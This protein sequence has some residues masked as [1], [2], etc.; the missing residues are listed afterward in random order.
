LR[1]HLHS[2]SLLPDRKSDGVSALASFSSTIR[3]CL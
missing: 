2:W 3:V 1:Q